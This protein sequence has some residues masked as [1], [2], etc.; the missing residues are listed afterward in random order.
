MKIVFVQLAN[1]AGE[2][3]VLEMLGQNSFSKALVLHEPSGYCFCV[4]NCVL[5]E[6]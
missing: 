3:A 2:V 6:F 1:K 5:D 4:A